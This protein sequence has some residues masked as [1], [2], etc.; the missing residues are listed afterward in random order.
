MRFR[1]WLHF[2][3]I[4]CMAAKISVSAVG[5]PLI[6]AVKKQDVQAVR[7][8]LKQQG[9]VN[10]TEADGFTALHWAAQRNDVQLVELLIGAGANAKASTRYNITPLYLAAVNGNAAVIERLLKAG[11]DP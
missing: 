1:G 2:V 9:N 7:T 5:S 3:G 11:A 10:A 6:E 4:G 8:L